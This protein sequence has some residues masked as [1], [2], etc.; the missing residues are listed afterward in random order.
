ME[1]LLYILIALFGCASYFVGLR[2]MLRGTYAPSL[3]SR[4]VWLLLAVNSFA[5]VILSQSTKASILLAGILLLGNAAICIASFWKGT[6]SIGRVEIGCLGLLFISLL[7]W[8]FFKAPLVNLLI[9][10][11]AHFIGAIPTYRRVWIN[12]KSES[13]AF[14]SLFFIA[15]V[16]SVVVSLGEPLKLVVLPL[17]FAL[18]D[19]S[20]CVLSLRHT[21]PTE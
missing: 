1:S 2:E 13:T 10:L 8:I 14:W 9:S 7:I 11:S 20:M 15:S 5:G 12:P 16:L 6:R 18:F 3:F 17:Y 19:G 21:N 4:V